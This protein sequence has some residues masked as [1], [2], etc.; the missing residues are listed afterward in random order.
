MYHKLNVLGLDS[1]T[2][3]RQACGRNKFFL[4]YVAELIPKPQEKL[5]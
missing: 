1:S 3:S 5:R 4:F 2:T